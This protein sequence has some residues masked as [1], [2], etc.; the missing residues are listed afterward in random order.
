MPPLPTALLP[1]VNPITFE[2]LFS[3]HD[4]FKDVE[5]RLWEIIPVTAPNLEAV[6]DGIDLLKP[7]VNDRLSSCGLAAQKYMQHA[8]TTRI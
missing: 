3:V 8:R 7:E 5:L 2:E 6:P 1:D 4:N